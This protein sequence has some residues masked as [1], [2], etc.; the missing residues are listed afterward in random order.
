MAKL[1]CMMG[2]SASG[3]DTIYKM[4]VQDTKLNLHTVVPYTT[5]P[6]REGEAA[7]VEYWFVDETQ[8]G[9]F[10]AEGKI[11]EDR[12]YHTVHG[13]WRYFMADDGQ[14]DFSKGNYIVIGTLESYLQIRKY[15]GEDVVVPVY[16]NV[17][18]GLR[19]TRALSRERQQAVP[20]YAELCRRFLAD[21]ED[22]SE[23]KL[24]AAGISRIFENDD[25]D[26]CILNIKEAIRKDLDCEGSDR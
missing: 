7:G 13:L 4:L 17:E 24:K 5:R 18:D 12:A 23:D 20:R 19:L 11:I 21:S 9:R 2:K 3:K 6:V 22:F 15:F 16:I 26:S 14:I 10:K 1:F 8:F 25:L